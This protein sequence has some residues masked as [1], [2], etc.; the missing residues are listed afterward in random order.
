MLRC[1]DI[2]AGDTDGNYDIEIGY[3]AI[4][5]IDDMTQLNQVAHEHIHHNFIVGPLM[6]CGGDTPPAG[7]RYHL[8]HNICVLTRWRAWRETKMWSWTLYT[9][10]SPQNGR[11]YRIYHNTFVFTNPR[12][13]STSPNTSNMSP[14]VNGLRNPQSPEFQNIMNNI[15]VV[16]N[17]DPPGPNALGT[18]TMG[19]MGQFSVNDTATRGRMDGNAYFRTFFDGL[20]GGFLFGSVTHSGGNSQN[21]ATLAGFKASAHFTASKSLYTPGWEN[22]GIEADPQFQGGSVMFTHEG[23]EAAP[24]D[25]IPQNPAYHTGAINLGSGGLNL[26]LPGYTHQAWRGALDPAGDGTEVGPR[27]A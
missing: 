9:P 7:N 5:V 12:R 18:G 1:F 21:F 10:H 24:A 2:A 8:H 6:G 23:R 14:G 22:S 19:W 3:N 13:E 20:S 26:G 4:E 25:Y 11:N 27:A 15:C 17:R 16:V